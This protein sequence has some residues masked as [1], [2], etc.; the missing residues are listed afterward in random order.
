MIINAGSYKPLRS[1]PPEARG[2]GYWNSDGVWIKVENEHGTIG[3]KPPPPYANG[4]GRWNS[5]G[6]WIE[7]G[8]KKRPAP[9]PPPP[10]PPTSHKEKNAFQAMT[11]DD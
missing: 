1:P 11:K 6:G 5:D 10:L 7:G 4:P 9:P 3:P 8:M 2:Q